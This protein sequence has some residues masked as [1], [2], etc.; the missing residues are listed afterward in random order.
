MCWPWGHLL[1][2]PF[3][4]EHEGCGK[5]FTSVF[6]LTRHAVTHTGEKSIKCDSEDCDLTFSLKSNMRRHFNRTHKYPNQI[7]V[8]YF[9]DCSKIFKKHNQLKVHQFIHTNQQPF[10]CTHEGCDK[11][12]S[13]PSRLKRHEKVHSGYSCKIDNSCS[14]VGKTWTDYL[15]H[16]SACH[17][18]PAICDV[19]NRRFKTKGYLKN[20]KKSHD[21]ERTVYCCPREGCDRTYTTA[22]NL[23]SHVLSFHEEQRPFVCE[24]TGCGKAFPLKQSLQRHSV[25][26]DPEKKKLK[27]KHPRPKRSLASRLSGYKPSKAAENAVVSEK[28]E[29]E[30]GVQNASQVIETN[31][32]LVLEALSLN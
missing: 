10:K 23:Q 4:C 18:E 26:H 1:H 16:V 12:F 7:Y 31:G 6:H 5:G 32:S 11:S 19:C 15:K 29:T 3:S 25:V 9:D 14:F 17:E 30:H 28:P 22:F 27:E 24:H 13:A 2:K 21:Q 8:C 20:H